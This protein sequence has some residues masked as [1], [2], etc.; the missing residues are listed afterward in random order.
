VEGDLDAGVPGECFE[1]RQVRSVDGVV[2]NVI[3]IP[4]RLVVVD[5]QA[6]SFRVTSPGVAARSRQQE[7]RWT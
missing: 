3:E 2:E 7:V 1:E 5:T 6:Q 4:H